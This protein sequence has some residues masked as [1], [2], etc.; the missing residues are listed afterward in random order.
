MLVSMG[1]GRLSYELKLRIS[2]VELVVD[3]VLLPSTHL[4]HAGDAVR[5]GELSLVQ[6]YACALAVLAVCS[7]GVLCRRY[8]AVRRASAGGRGV[9]GLSSPRGVEMAVKRRGGTTPGASHSGGAMSGALRAPRAEVNSV[10]QAGTSTAAHTVARARIRPRLGPL[11]KEQRSP[12]LHSVERPTWTSTESI[13][14]PWAKDL[15]AAWGEST[16]E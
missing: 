7:L 16:R 4:A 9:Y 3:G 1:C 14:S 13:E 12:I 6:V 11:E 2:S 8:R 5:D 10:A 15:D